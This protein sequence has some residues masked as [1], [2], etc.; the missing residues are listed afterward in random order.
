[1]FIWPGRTMSL[2]VEMGP[3]VQ[4][5]RTTYD[6][7][8]AAECIRKTDCPLVEELSVRYVLNPP[9]EAESLE[10]FTTVELQ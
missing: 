6:F 5:R 2:L 7:T 9:T 3:D 1:M 8:A 4:L 10:L